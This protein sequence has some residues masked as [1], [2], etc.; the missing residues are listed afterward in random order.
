MTQAVVV[1]LLQLLLFSIF[2]ALAAPHTH[3]HILNYLPS[4]LQLLMV[5]LKF[6]VILVLFRPHLPLISPLRFIGTS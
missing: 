2:L 4:L 6:L 3:N 5:F 1:R